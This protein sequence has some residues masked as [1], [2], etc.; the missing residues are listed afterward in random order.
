MEAQL[1]RTA[2]GQAGQD[3]AEKRGRGCARP[4]RLVGS[5]A[6]VNKATG[7]VGQT[8]SSAQELDGTTYVR[9]GNR[10]A[11]V[12]PTCSHEDKGDA[13]HV[14]ARGLAGG[15][16]VPADVANRPCT[17]S[18]LTAPSIGPVHGVRDEG[19]CRARRDKPVCEHGRPL[20]CNKRHTDTD[21]RLGEPLCFDCYDYLAHWLQA[22]A[23]AAAGALGGDET[24]HVSRLDVDRWLRDDTEEDPEVTPRSQHRVGSPPTGEELKVVI[25][26]RQPRAAPPA[27]QRVLESESGE[28]RTGTFRGLHRR[29]ATAAGRNVLEDHVQNKADPDVAGAMEYAGGV[30]GSRRPSSCG[31]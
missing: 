15:K 28:G 2:I 16:G 9:C 23:I 10:R 5:T 7:E 1:S 3:S 12:C 30:N 21:Q 11:S 22:S 20:W 8:Y 13:W 4:I 19:P 24:Q 6:V 14:L 17:F 26:Q 25:D 31:T 18:T 27:H 29:A